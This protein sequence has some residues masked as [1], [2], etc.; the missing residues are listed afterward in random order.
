MGFQRYRHC[1]GSRLES[2]R[3]SDETT[4]MTSH[5]HVSWDERKDS[6]SNRP[7]YDGSCC[8]QPRD[9]SARHVSISQMHLAPSFSGKERGDQL[10][11][12]GL[13]R[14]G[15]RGS[16]PMGLA[17]E[18]ASKPPSVRIPC[19]RYGDCAGFKWVPGPTTAD[20]MIEAI[21]CLRLADPRENTQGHRNAPR[22]CP[23]KYKAG[24]SHVCDIFTW[25]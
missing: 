25:M 20:A 17:R 2:K 13:V 10:A 21:K 6:C 12:I 7:S 18:G 23:L 4:E 3:Y 9:L 14:E 22:W 5:T 8:H 15:A 24:L 1:D 16:L 19:V 11:P